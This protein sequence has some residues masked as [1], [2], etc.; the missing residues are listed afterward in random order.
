MS[1]I[2]TE[3]YNRRIDDV[4]NSAEAQR[5]LKAVYAAAELYFSHLRQNGVHVSGLTI[6]NE[7]IATGAGPRVEKYITSDDLWSGGNLASRH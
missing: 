3:D 7:S 4:A 5:L 1:E 2:M 6:A